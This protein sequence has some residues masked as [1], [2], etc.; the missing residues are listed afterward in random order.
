MS[1]HY[2]EGTSKKQKKKEEGRVVSPVWGG[3]G[4]KK[5]SKPAEEERSDNLGRARW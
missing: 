3:V 5:T 1:T 2:R 4:K